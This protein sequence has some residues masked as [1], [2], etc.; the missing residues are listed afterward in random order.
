MGNGLV[1]E[2]RD[3]RDSARGIVFVREGREDTDGAW[4][5]GVIGE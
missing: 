2:R 4:G 1:P 3:V 5:K